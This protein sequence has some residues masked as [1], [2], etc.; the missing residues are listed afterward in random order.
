MCNFVI[1]MGEPFNRQ[2]AAV[3]G[4]DISTFGNIV[5]SPLSL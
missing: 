1:V 3:Y 2:C 4:I 5:G